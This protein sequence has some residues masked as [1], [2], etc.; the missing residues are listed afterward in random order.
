MVSDYFAIN[1]LFAYHEIAA[2]KET[3]A[4]MALQAG[5]DVELPGTDCYAD[6]LRRAL[7]SGMLSMDV[8]DLSVRRVLRMKFLLGLFEQ[9]YV[10]AGRVLP[11]F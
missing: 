5:L 4:A 3:A 6:P 10:D 1:Q 11:G 8:L 7:E 9:P 2:N